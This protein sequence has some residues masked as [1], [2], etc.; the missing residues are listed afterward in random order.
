MKIAVSATGP[1][2]EAAVDPRFG[3]CSFFIIA[4]TESPDFTAIEN[5]NIALSGGAGIQSAQMMAEKGVQTVL[6]G[7][8][9]PNASNTFSATGIEVITGCS[10][11]VK[12]VINAFKSGSYTNNQQ[13]NQDISPNQTSN[14]PNFQ[15]SN[16]F[17]SRT[18]RMGQGRGCGGGRGMGGGGGRC[19]GGG[20]G[21]GMGGGGRGMGGGQGGGKGGGRG[22]G[23]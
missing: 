2:L 21:K 14:T 7:S 19:M 10:G 9:G 3:R 18:S 22:M 4:E 1:T 6:T 15:Q 11:M 20:G 17:G 5:P 12:D 8:C 13:Q 23:R 16:T